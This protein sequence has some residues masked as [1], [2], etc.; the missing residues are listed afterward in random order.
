M[1]IVDF[2][3][4]PNLATYSKV[5]SS[6]VAQSIAFGSIPYLRSCKQKTYMNILKDPS[7]FQNMFSDIG[8][9]IGAIMKNVARHGAALD[10]ITAM[11]NE[12][13]AE[14]TLSVALWTP[15]TLDARLNSGNTVK[16]SA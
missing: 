11:L 10:H 4:S 13:G 12:P 8:V 2:G 1:V 3:A 16:S 7:K 9:P 14:N 15:S 6:C 5:G